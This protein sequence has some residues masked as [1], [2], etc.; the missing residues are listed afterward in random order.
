MKK[1]NKH[2]VISF[3]M[4]ILISLVV[5]SCKNPA[6]WYPEGQASIQTVQEILGEP[7]QVIC[8]IKI[9]NTGKSKIQRTTV[10]LS[11]QTN[12]HE[13]Y[14]TLVN[15]T[16]ILPETFIFTH[17]AVPFLDESETLI[18]TSVKIINDFFE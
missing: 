10:S 8:T 15:E 9:K 12:L 13:Y 6:D 14:S 4:C 7:K 17:V 16:I 11:L 2:N 5:I 3:Y 1:N 18:P